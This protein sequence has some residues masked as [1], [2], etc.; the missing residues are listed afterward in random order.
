M[1]DPQGVIDSVS[2]KWTPVFNDELL[3][4]HSEY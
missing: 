3:N 1:G 4:L 2:K